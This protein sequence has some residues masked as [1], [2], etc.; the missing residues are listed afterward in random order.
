M[1]EFLC[2][3]GYVHVHSIPSQRATWSFLVFPGL[4]GLATCA[5]HFYPQ[6]FSELGRFLSQVNVASIRCLGHNELFEPVMRM[7]SFLL[8]A[9]GRISGWSSDYKAGDNLLS[10]QNRWTSQAVYR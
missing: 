5:G 2:V 7:P 10:A 9:E 6:T 8:K 4:P 3:L 1:N